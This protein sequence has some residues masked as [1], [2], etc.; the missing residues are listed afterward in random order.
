MADAVV[1]HARVKAGEG[2][3]MPRELLVLAVIAAAGRF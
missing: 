3:G 2:T 1:T